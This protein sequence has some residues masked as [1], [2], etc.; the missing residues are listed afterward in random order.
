VRGRLWAPRSA[1]GCTLRASASTSTGRASALHPA[2]PAGLAL[3]CSRRAPCRLWGVLA[4]T[5]ASG[6][7]AARRAPHAR[8]G[9]IGLP[10]LR[11]GRVGVGV[12][13]ALAGIVRS[14]GVNGTTALPA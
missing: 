14:A 8:A 6:T 9:I 12:L 1:L 11:S 7:G 13:V 5:L 4:L 2:P 3:A 10:L